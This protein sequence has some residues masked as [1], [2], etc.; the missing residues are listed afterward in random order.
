MV[1]T[2]VAVLDFGSQY[3]Q[4]IVRRVRELGYLARLYAP[5]ALDELEDPAALILSGGPR[6]VSTSAEDFLDSERIRGFG[7]PVLGICYGMQMLSAGTGGTVD[8]SAAGE[9]GPAD[10]T[11]TAKD[12]LFAGLSRELTVWMSHSDTVTDRPPEA[13]VLA[14]NRQ[15]T[16]VALAWDDDVYGLQ[17]HPEVS[18]TEGGTRILEN[19][20]TTIPEPPAFSMESF[21]DELVEDVRE[22]VGEKKVLCAV[23]G[24]V[25][26]TVLAVLLEQT[27]VDLHPVFVDTG[28]MRKNEAEEVMGQFDE[29]DIEVDEVDASERFLAAIEGITDPE[30][31]RRRIGDVFL[32]EFFRAAGDF[33][34]LAQ[35]TLYPDVIES[36]SS[37]SDA[38]TIK[39]H[40]NRV[41]RIMELEREGRVIEPLSELFKDEVRDLGRTL[42]IPDRILH[43]H[44]FPGPGLAIRIP[45][46]V[47]PE[48][49]A[50]L[51]EADA[52][53]LQALRE[54]DWYDHVW[55]AFCV[56]LPVKTVGVKGDR[57][58]HEY[59]V[60]VRAVTSRDGMT[61]DWARL[62]DEL[63]ATISNRILNRVE[64]VNRVLYDVSTKPPSSIEWE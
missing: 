28:L 34:L 38:D 8:R 37:G 57:R 26:S 63:L 14:E 50:M 44:P 35:G 48:R 60:S 30:E 46:E 12:T 27:G 47:T 58:S 10:I 18:H 23:S 7:V 15:G 52:L 32:D 40:H 19:F 4:L 33:D 59:A 45:G 43:R 13:S 36:A 29:L 2:Q 41:D 11:V 53:Y 49:L 55:Q 9:Y 42:G 20:L 22:T 17:F 39:T 54:S 61:A 51:R 64:G 3:S 24:G 56:L 1:K 6:S 62:P 21:R 5:D 31:K 16:P 25:D